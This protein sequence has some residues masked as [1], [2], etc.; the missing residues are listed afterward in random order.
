MAGEAAR[1]NDC[2]LISHEQ[3]HVLAE[4]TDVVALLP[5]TSGTETKTNCRGPRAALEE[6]NGEDDTEGQ[7]KTRSD[8]HRGEAAVPLKITVSCCFLSM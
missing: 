6:E 5:C 2:C 4:N 1:L 7:T 3:L 8:E